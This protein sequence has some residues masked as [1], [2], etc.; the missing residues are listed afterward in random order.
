[1]KATVEAQTR[2]SSA[3]LVVPARIVPGQSIGEVVLEAA[4]N[5]CY[6]SAGLILSAAGIEYRGDPS[7]FARARGREEDLAV[8]LD[9]PEGAEFLRSISPN[10][11]QGRPG[12]SKFFGVPLRDV[13]RD[14]RY[15]RVSPRRLKE[16]LHLKAIWSIKVFSFDP[17]T[18]EVLLVRCPECGRRP[19]Y[20]RTYGIQYCEFCGQRDEYGFPCGKVDFRDFPQPLIEVEDVEALDFAI[21]LLDPEHR[22]IRAFDRIHPELSQFDTGDLFELI[23][24]TACALTTRPSWRASTLDRPSRQEDYRRF[25]PDVLAKAARMLL[26]WPDGFHGVAADIRENAACRNGYFGVRKELGPLVAMSMDAHLRPALR[27]VIRDRIRVDMTMTSGVAPTTRRAEYRSSSDF[28]PIQQAAQKYGMSRRAISR[29]VKHG[30]LRAKRVSGAIK[31]PVLVDSPKL[32]EIVGCR[33][34]GISSQAVA[35]ELGIPRAYLSSLADAGYL[36]RLTTESLEAFRGEFYLKDSV[37]ELRRRCEQMAQEEPPPEGFVRITKAVNRLG[38]ADRNPWP[39]IVGRILSGE[40]RI[41]RVEGRLTA[42]MT[43]HAVG[44]IH[45]LALADISGTQPLDE[46]VVFTQQEAADFLHISPVRVNGLVRHGFLPSQPKMRDLRRFAETF[47]LTAEIA[48]WLA[49]K[50]TPATW[51]DIPR[52]LQEAGISPVAVL[53]RN[54]GYLWRRSEVADYIGLVA[55]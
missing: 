45:E 6:R 8:T 54:R 7:V 44:H 40:L 49:A 15:R 38:L 37:V 2:L 1:M 36:V 43:S 29:L 48:D 17:Q 52:L 24:A 25:T 32:A 11:I 4:A 55:Q 50:G 14:F 10:P 53:N 51:R 41:W 31:A 39:Q 35:V 20:L 42:L 13:H 18:K 12:W 19:T 9:N 47:V 22:N 5:N 30:V 23:V 33:L 16:S 21:A 34:A 3:R 28:I 26:D 27:R 46:G